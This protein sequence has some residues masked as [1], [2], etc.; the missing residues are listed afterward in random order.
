MESRTDVDWDT[1]SY[2][3]SS[4]VRLKVL[5][6]LIRNVSTPTKLS[7]NLKEPIS[8]ISTTLRELTEI[9]AV[10]CL[11]PERRKGKIYH[12]TEKGKR[13]IEVIHNMTD[14]R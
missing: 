5:I 10:E 4:E 1:I 14:I 11:T 6:H 9:G 13:I 2:V 3:I 12:A 8:R 7:E